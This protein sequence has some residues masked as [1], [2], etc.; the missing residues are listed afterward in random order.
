MGTHLIRGTLQILI[1]PCILTL[2]TFSIL[3][4]GIVQG[5]VI[6]SY[7]NIITIVSIIIQI[8][9][10]IVFINWGERMNTQSNEEERKRYP[11]NLLFWLF[12]VAFSLC[13]GNIYA[14]LFARSILIFLPKIGYLAIGMGIISGLL[15]F[16]ILFRECFIMF[17]WYVNS[18][19]KNTPNKKITYSNIEKSINEG[20]INKVSTIQPKY[21]LITN[22]LL[23]VLIFAIIIVIILYLLD[24]GR[25]Q[26]NIGLNIFIFI[27]I[28]TLG[29][30]WIYYK[31]W[32]KELQGLPFSGIM[33]KRKRL[34]S[35][36]AGIQ[37]GELGILIVILYIIKLINYSISRG[38]L[39]IIYFIPVWIF[40]L[41]LLGIIFIAPA[42]ALI[43][44]SLE[45]SIEWIKAFFYF[46][47]LQK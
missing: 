33:T 36:I 25:Q 38:E 28:I 23:V 16:I 15:L 30:C 47:E 42:I 41:L 18:V 46:S 45:L 2:A 37:I 20:E 17:K 3:V 40:G 39:V 31:Y 19:D 32:K 7:S 21:F 44:Y 24:I 1:I 27:N 22:L 34:F 8:A 13:I 11:G 4:I 12:Y 43:G 5:E 6:A 9:L 14:F 10:P 35:F 26:I 29:I